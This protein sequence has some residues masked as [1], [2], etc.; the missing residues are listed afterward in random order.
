V[1]ED[2]YPKSFLTA[3]VSSLR[4]LGNWRLRGLGWYI[5]SSESLDASRYL[6]KLFLLVPCVLS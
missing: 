6:L 3:L 4:I 2:L 5:Y 1:K